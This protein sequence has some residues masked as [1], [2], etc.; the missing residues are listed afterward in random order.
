MALVIKD[1]PHVFD[2][3]I[4]R[5]PGQLDVTQESACVTYSLE[6]ALEV[7]LGYKLAQ[8]SHIDLAVICVAIC[9]FLLPFRI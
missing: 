6:Q 2:C 5:E 9:A 7:S 1:H 8:S 4:L 3:A